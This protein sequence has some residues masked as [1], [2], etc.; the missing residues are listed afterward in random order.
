MYI[1]MYIYILYIY[2]CRYIHKYCQK[3]KK[4]WAQIHS[5]RVTISSKLFQE[6]G[7]TKKKDVTEELKSHKMNQNWQN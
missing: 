4:R 5:V 2:I 7:L 6:M 1:Y 3:T